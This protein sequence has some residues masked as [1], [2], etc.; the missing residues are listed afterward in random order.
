M[1]IKSSKA[2][3]AAMVAT[4]VISMSMLTAC[5]GRKMSNMTPTGDT[6]E[7]EVARPDSPDSTSVNPN[8]ISDTL[9]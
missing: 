6:V 7:L 8:P 2:I 9:L 3:A 5:E 1:G 4:I